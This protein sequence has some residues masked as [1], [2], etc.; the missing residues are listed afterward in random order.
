MFTSIYHSACMA[1]DCGGEYTK[2]RVG[3]DCNRIWQHVSSGC[4]QGRKESTSVTTTIQWNVVGCYQGILLYKY[5]CIEYCS[6]HFINYS[7]QVIDE[8][9]FKN[10]TDKICRDKYDPSVIKEKHPGVSFMSAEQTF[11]WLTRF[12]KILSAMPKNHHLFYLHRLVKKRNIYTE[13]CHRLNRKPLL[14]KTK[15]S[16]KLWT[17]TTFNQNKVITFFVTQIL[18]I[19][20]N[21]KWTIDWESVVCC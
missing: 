10:H 3:K 14:P 20:G 6:L 12:R 21:T 15:D 9:H 5:M 4:S 17:S 19:L 7:L 2:R 1:H 8:L 13:L 18:T 11:A 16:K